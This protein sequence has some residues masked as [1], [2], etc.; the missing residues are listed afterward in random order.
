[1]KALDKKG[2][3]YSFCIATKAMVYGIIFLITGITD[4]G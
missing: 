2:Q 4:Q 3:F 1:M